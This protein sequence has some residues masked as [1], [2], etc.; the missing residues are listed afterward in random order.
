MKT[1]VAPPR[2]FYEAGVDIDVKVGRSARVREVSDL[3]DFSAE[4]GVSLTEKSERR[5]T[6]W[7]LLR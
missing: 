1:H 2:F 6:E 3:Y 7:F 5:M 4:L